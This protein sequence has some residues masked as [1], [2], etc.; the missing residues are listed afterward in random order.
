M[1]VTQ[2]IVTGAL[3]IVPAVNGTVVFIRQQRGPYAGHWLLPGGKVEP[4]EDLEQTARREAFEEAGV[5]VATMTPTGLYDIRGHAAGRSYRFMMVAFLAGPESPRTAA[6][7]H[8]VEEVY[9]A[10]PGQVRPHPTVMRILNDAG[11]GRYDPGLVEA[12]LRRDAITMRVY[13]VSGPA[14]RSHR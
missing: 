2:P 7:G 1:T 6:G 9:I 10:A 11:I 12:G 4:G 13:P 3:A 5:Q 8:H 14:C